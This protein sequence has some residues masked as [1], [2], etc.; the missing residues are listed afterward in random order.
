MAQ[1][2]QV[3]LPGMAAPSR[4]PA[5]P[6]DFLA[7]VRQPDAEQVLAT[8]L[9]NPGCSIGQAVQISGL[10]KR[11]LIALLDYLVAAGHLATISVGRAR[12]VFPTL[13][14]LHAYSRQFLDLRD[15]CKALM[16]DWMLRQQVCRRS[17]LFQQAGS[18]WHW[19]DVPTK[20]RLAALVRHGLVEVSQEMRVDRRLTWL[21]ALHPS[22]MVQ[23]LVKVSQGHLSPKILRQLMQDA[24][25]ISEPL[26][27]TLRP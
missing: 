11:R 27:P 25:P 12:I 5:S 20:K 19:P 26:W 23:Q 7:L 22:P 18:Q 14:G 4:M 17:A 13:P 8:V 9:E 16:H 1:R 24:L 10:P 6:R 3:L 15:P 2:E 21:K